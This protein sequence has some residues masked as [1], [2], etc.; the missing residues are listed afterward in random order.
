M[1]IIQPL[2]PNWKID[3]DSSIH[4]VEQIRQRVRSEDNLTFCLGWPIIKSKDI[5]H[6]KIQNRLGRD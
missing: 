1:Q 3:K 2:K 4:P 6:G 5:K